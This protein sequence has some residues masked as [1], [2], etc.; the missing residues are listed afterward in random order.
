MSLAVYSGSFW[1]WPGGSV[2]AKDGVW[3]LRS[4][5]GSILNHAIG[6]LTA[7]GDDS[8]LISDNSGW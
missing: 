3:A 2:S 8:V 4:L 7:D 5:F 6:D 1:V